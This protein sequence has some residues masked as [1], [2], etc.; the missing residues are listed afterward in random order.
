MVVIHSELSLLSRLQDWYASMCND[1]WEHTYGV[2]IS[3]ID[4]PG[5]A[6][7][8]E[9]KDTYL[10]DVPFTDVK[11][12]RDDENDWMLCK[13]EQGNFQGYGGLYNLSEMIEVFLKGAEGEENKHSEFQ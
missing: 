8:V 11:V 4:N 2:S 6:L 3:N 10:Y 12:Q 5:W 1:D 9:L 13:L 7:K